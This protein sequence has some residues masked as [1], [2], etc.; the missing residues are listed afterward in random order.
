M[1]FRL[2][3]RLATSLATQVREQGER[4]RQI[5]SEG[6]ASELDGAIATL[7]ELKT[8]LPAGHELAGGG[9]KKKKK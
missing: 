4:V 8:R 9:K 5:K 2:T 3:P 6:D 1:Y 7:L